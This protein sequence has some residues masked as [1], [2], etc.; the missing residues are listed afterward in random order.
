MD[1]GMTV[2]GILIERLGGGKATKKWRRRKEEGA[3][4]LSRHAGAF[5]SSELMVGHMD[6]RKAS[7]LAGTALEIED[8]VEG[9]N[10]GCMRNG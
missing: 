1:S 7:R 4:H 5:I 3:L 2:A 10:E 6:G 9:G 8:G